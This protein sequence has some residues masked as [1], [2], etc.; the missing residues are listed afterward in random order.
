MKR[1]PNKKS[2]QDFLCRCT[3]CIALEHRTQFSQRQMLEL[4]QLLRGQQRLLRT[5]REAVSRSL[6][7]CR[8][9]VPAPNNC[10][11]LDKRCVRWFTQANIF[12]GLMTPAGKS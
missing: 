12:Y 8:F 1:I 3:V 10:A 7:C 11:G 2:Y 9:D 5:L 4:E 6:L